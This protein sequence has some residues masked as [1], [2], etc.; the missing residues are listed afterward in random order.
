MSVIPAPPA[1]PAPPPPVTPP[2][3]T[4]LAADYIVARTGADQ[5]FDGMGGSLVQDHTTS[6]ISKLSLADSDQ[7]R[8]RYDSAA[9][10]YQVSLPSSASWQQLY[11]DTSYAPNTRDLVSG[12]TQHI[13]LHLQE[14][15]GT[16]YL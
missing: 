7:L 2:P 11:L 3:T 12:G 16:G 10:Q 9:K 15:A 1:T 6:A 14:Y 13:Q 4:G 8:I 5:S